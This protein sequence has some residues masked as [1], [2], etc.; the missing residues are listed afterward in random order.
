MAPNRPCWVG[1]GPES[2]PNGANSGCRGSFTMWCSDHCGDDSEVVS[3]VGSIWDQWQEMSPCWRDWVPDRVGDPR[4]DL[5][6]LLRGGVSLSL[7]HGPW[8]VLPLCP[9]ALLCF[10]SLWRHASLTG[11]DGQ[12]RV[13]G[14]VP[15]CLLVRRLCRSRVGHPW[16]LPALNCACSGPRKHR[17]VG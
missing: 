2:N 15:S 17:P 16:S 10:F 9:V 8:S 5:C 11:C 7:P 4:N 12:A 6:R 13:V 14:C 1:S 3:V